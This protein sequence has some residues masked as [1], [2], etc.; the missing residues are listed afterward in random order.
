MEVEQVCGAPYNEKLHQLPHSAELVAD[1]RHVGNFIFHLAKSRHISLYFTESNLPDEVD[2]RLGL[3]TVCMRSKIYHI[4][5]HLFPDTVDAV[6]EAFREKDRTE[7]CPVFTYRW[8]RLGKE[9][10]KI[11]KWEPTRNIMAE[12]VANELGMKSTLDAYVDYTVGGTSCRRGTNFVDAAIPSQVA[13]R[14]RAIRATVVYEFVVKAKK[15][16]QEEA[17]R[18]RHEVAYFHPLAGRLK[19]DR[20]AV[21]ESGERRS[22]SG[23]SQ[24]N[25]KKKRDESSGSASRAEKR[26]RG[27]EDD[28]KDS[29]DGDRRKDQNRDHHRS[30]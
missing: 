8:V 6:G 27:R 12:T 15:L 25:R 13:L 30:R 11:F 7:E 18:H 4:M 22:S 3:V 24:F 19:P 28:K 2:S 1:K 16:R 17:S 23:G 29:R 14:H 26:P 9:F 20:E 21:A 5:P 10:A